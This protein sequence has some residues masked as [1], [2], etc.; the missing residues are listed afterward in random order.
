MEILRNGCSYNGLT[1]HPADWNQPGAFLET[2]WY[3]Q[4]RFTDPTHIDRYPQGKLCLVKKGIN[5]LST[6]AERRSKVKALLQEIKTK[7][8]SGFNP[9]TKGK[10]DRDHRVSK[11]AS[12]S[13]S[14]PN[15][16]G[17][18]EIQ[19]GMPFI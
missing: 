14:A 5:S 9:I 16:S 4:Y 6:L 13:A 12:K 19:P 1:V 7:L 11:G 18:I 2:E 17:I 10:T 8:D 15:P 3:I